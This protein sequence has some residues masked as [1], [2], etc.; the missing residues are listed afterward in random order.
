MRRN[1]ELLKAILS[2]MQDDEKPTQCCKDIETGVGKE[3][4][5]SWPEVRLHLA[6]LKDMGLV[7]ECT[8]AAEYRL[9]SAGYDVVESENPIEQMRAWAKIGS[10]P[11]TPLTPSFSTSRH[12]LP[13][14]IHSQR[15][16]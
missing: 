8:T 15:F 13:P 16:T 11:N 3:A 12:P 6:L 9:T 14:A 2:F 4:G 10:S 7:T 1:A 5:H